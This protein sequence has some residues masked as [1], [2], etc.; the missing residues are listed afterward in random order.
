MPPD[1]CELC[2]AAQE[3]SAQIQGLFNITKS[4]NSVTMTT[5]LQATRPSAAGTNSDHLD[6]GYKGNTHFFK[7]HQTEPRNLDNRL[8]PHTSALEMAQ[9]LAV[10]GGSV[11]RSYLSRL[12]S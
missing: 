10:K 2:W 5:R 6:A 3:G 1:V 11:P 7:R 4:P 9:P 12:W 8:P